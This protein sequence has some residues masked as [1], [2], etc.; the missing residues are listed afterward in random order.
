MPAV[1]LC[2][3]PVGADWRV[4]W[5][6]YLAWVIPALTVAAAKTWMM[7]F[8]PADAS[9]TI[10]LTTIVCVAW[11]ALTALP[12]WRGMLID[13]GRLLL[14]KVPVVV[15]VAV[16]CV[17]VVGGSSQG[18]DRPWWAVTLWVLGFTVG[19]GCASYL[20]SRKRFAFTLAV[21]AFT[22]LLLVAIDAL[23]GAYVLRRMTHNNI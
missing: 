10:L 15:W 2:T 14:A 4:I 23:V 12:S 5:L 13:I 22:G 17:L 20:D 1:S 18:L 6:I 8:R 3:T 7:H 19:A 16:A 11:V 21:L 9:P